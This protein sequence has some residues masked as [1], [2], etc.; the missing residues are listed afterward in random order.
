MKVYK[1]VSWDVKPA[2]EITYESFI[3][4]YDKCFSQV[5]NAL[6]GYLKIGGWCYDFRDDLRKYLVKQYGE[7]REVYAP[8][9]TAIRKSIY[10][11]IKK[12]IELL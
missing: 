12:I 1:F 5:N 3:Q 11:R 2:Q 6:S 8:N 4:N 10:G 9:K 7:W